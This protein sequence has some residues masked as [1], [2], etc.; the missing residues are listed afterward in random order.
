M[1]DLIPFVH[2]EETKR[3]KSEI[4]GVP[5]SVIFDGTSQLGEALAII[6]H[7]IS[8]SNFTILQRLVKLQVLRK[9]LCW[10]RNCQRSH[11]CTFNINSPDL[12]AAMRD[13]ASANS[14]AL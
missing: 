14:V 5:V 13:H 12:L 4:K 1:S 10:R 2:S 6:L 3:I 11:F 9:T 7:F 8:P